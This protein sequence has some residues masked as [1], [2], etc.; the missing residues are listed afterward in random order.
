MVLTSYVILVYWKLA[1]VEGRTVVRT[2][3]EFSSY[4]P[5]RPYWY[6]ELGRAFRRGSGSV[7][8]LRANARQLVY[9]WIK[10]IHGG[11]SQVVRQWIV[12]PP[13]RGFDSRRSP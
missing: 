10:Y 3:F 11:R 12:T 8:R 4:F 2:L 1:T 6:T 13:F 5:Y 9:K 7:T